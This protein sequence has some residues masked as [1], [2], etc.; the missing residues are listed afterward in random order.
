MSHL[1]EKQTFQEDEY[2]FPYHYM[3][4]KSEYY[5]LIVNIDN[6]NLLDVVINMLRPFKGQLILDIG[7]GDGRLC[8]ELKNNNVEIVGVDFSEQAI[9]FA[10]AFNP[11]VEFFVQDIEQLNLPYQFDQIVLMEVLEHFMPSKIPLILRNISNL[12]KDDGKLLITTPSTNLAIE[13]K[14][15]Q[16]FT[17]ESLQATIE[18]YFNILEISGVM[19]KNHNHFF[20][21]MRKIGYLAYP[22]RNNIAVARNFISYINKY[23]KKHFIGNPDECY[24]LIAVCGKRNLSFTK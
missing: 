10:K 24:G 16:H 21:L 20:N 12:L 3:D 1:T 11:G 15:Y 14:H 17:K 19:S 13:S 8:Y 6:L 22:F 23:S 2:S 5:K 18:Q 7:C 4:L 9:R